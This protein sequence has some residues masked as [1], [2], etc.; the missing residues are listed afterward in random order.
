MS[1]QVLVIGAGVVGLNTAWYAA[2]RGWR[3]T[4]LDR[5]PAERAGAS[6]VNAGYVTPSHVVPLA[7]PGMMRVAFKY[8]WDD[9]SPFYIKPRLDPELISWGWKFFRASTP[10]RVEQAAPVLRDLNFGSLACYR[11]L[12]R[13]LGDD[14]GFA[15]TGILN[16]ATTEEGF[17]KEVNKGEFATRI[18]SRGEVVTPADVERMEP[19]LRIRTTGGVFYPDDAILAPYRFMAVMGR[20]LAE[21]GVAFLWETEVTGW[22]T[23]G[24]RIDAVRTSRGEHSADEFLV[25][26]GAW[27]PR[28]VA[29][30]AVKLPMQGGKG[31]SMTLPSPPQQAAH[32]IILTEARVAITPIGQALRF[33]GT[34]EIAGLDERMNPARVRG[35]VKAA[36]K[37]LPD[38][39]EEDFATA[40]PSSGLRPCSPD[41]LPY[42]GRPARW[43]NLALGTGHA[44]MGMSLGPITGKLLAEVLAGEPPSVSLALLSPDRYL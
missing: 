25:C 31:Y 41:G 38:F 1:K 37:H 44:M 22:R 30:L 18:G 33:G 23:S 40:T 17:A 43:D 20:R 36:L 16:L 42:V 10:E 3:V 29:G 6:Y 15:E 7:A 26:G 2:E 11:Q 21:R 4:V 5:A 12:A 19:R 14:F 39:S 24:R 35:I 34:M 8:M 13:D 28:V 32:G 9:E 27:S